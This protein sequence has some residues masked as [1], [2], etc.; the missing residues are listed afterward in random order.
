[1][2]PVAAAAVLAAAPLL[3]A[4]FKAIRGDVMAAGTPAAGR[5]AAA[6]A[7]LLRSGE[8]DL[9]LLPDLAAGMI[10]AAASCWRC[11]LLSILPN[12]APLSAAALPAVAPLDGGRPSLLLP[13]RPAAAPAA[14][15]VVAAAVPAC[16]AA[17][18]DAVLLLPCL[19]AAMP[20]R[21]G[22][23]LACWSPGREQ[24]HESGIVSELYIAAMHTPA[25]LAQAWLQVIPPRSV[26]ATTWH[27][28]LGPVTSHACS[29]HY[30]APWQH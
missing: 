8:L 17:A 4:A 20:A 15:E 27:H 12:A 7:V 6:A 9:L 2:A 21:I 22:C 24:Q 11:L 26:P 28:A 1:V 25:R 13:S 10:D 19:P 23:A 3:A 14:V 16:P 30:T 18:A 29:L 5:A